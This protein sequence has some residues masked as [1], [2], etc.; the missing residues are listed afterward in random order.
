MVCE[1]LSPRMCILSNNVVSVSSAEPV[2]NDCYYNSATDSI[3][4]VTWPSR[5]LETR[6]W[7][8]ME[9]CA[10]KRM[11]IL[12]FKESFHKNLNSNV[13]A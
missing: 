11:T 4:T 1:Y 3:N 12:C 6:I 7:L 10:S 8:S 13:E 2:R 9:R 5:R